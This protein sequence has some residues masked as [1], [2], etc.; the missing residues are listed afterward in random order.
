MQRLDDTLSY[1]H[2]RLTSSC[3]LRS[4]S[5]LHF[6]YEFMIFMDGRRKKTL[7]EFIARFTVGKIKF[8]IL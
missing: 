3:G 5:F 1:T 8:M 2:N 7:I 6:H 4:A